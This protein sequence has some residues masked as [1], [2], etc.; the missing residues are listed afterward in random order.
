MYSGHPQNEGSWDVFLWKNIL[1]IDKEDEYMY[2]KDERNSTTQRL[3][4]KE[5]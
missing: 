1:T 4:D 5:G 2:K 3:E